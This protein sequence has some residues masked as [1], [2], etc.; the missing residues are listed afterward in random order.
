MSENTS[1]QG[2]ADATDRFGLETALDGELPRE[3]VAR[4]TAHAE[5]CPECAEEMA[6][7]RAL[8]EL[9]RRSCASETAPRTLRERISIQYSRIE[10]T[11]S[12]GSASIETRTVR[13]SS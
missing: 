8:K 5:G 3:T 11:H 10:V 2:T 12:Q 13:R 7:L 1:P 9:V 6:R 4:M